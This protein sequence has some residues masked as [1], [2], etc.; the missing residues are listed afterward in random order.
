MNLTVIAG[1]NIS[2]KNVNENLNI[3]VKLIKNNTIGINILKFAIQWQL[4]LIRTVIK[5][6]PDKVIML[7]HAGKI[8]YNI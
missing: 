8:N 4:R 6:K 3:D 7:W 2:R 5:I 1:E